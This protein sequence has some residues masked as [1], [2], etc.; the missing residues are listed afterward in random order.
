MVAGVRRELPAMVKLALPVVAAELGWVAMSLVDTIMVG[1]VSSV[2]L[3]A[4]SIGGTL[5][6]TLATFAAGLM[7]GLDTL[8]AQAYGA[9]DVRDCHR[10]LMNAVYLYLPLAPVIMFAVWWVGPGLAAF[11]VNR[12][13][14]RQA[15]EYLR[16]VAWGSLPLL[17]Y[18]AFRRYLQA[19][20]LVK[21]VMFAL[22]SA[23]LV[24]LLANW[25]FIYGNWGAPALGAMG[26]GWAT[27]YSRVYMAGC[28]IA[29]TAWH[30]RKYRTGWM[31]VS[32]RPDWGRMRSLLRLGLPAGFQ[33]SL[34]VG[35]F[36]AATALVGRLAPVTLAAH[37][38]VL[39][40][41]TITYMV[42]LAIGS[43]AAV[44]V[45]QAVGRG[46]KE[47]ARFAGWTAILLG[48]A[49][50]SLMGL[51]F[52]VVPRGILRVFT[53][54][55][56]V[57]E[58]GVALLFVAAVFQLFDGVQ[59]VS[60]GALRGLGDTDTPMICNLVGYWLV[61]LPVGYWLCF[62]RGVGAVGLWVGLCFA[63]ILIGAA[64]LTVWTQ[65]SALRPVLASTG[66]R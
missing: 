16:A 49:F 59:T 6:Y 45:G 53:E 20:N 52:L 55:A 2:A 26:A 29:Y 28:L 36:A 62:T 8:V 11:G 38:I 42:P 56:G 19:M 50:M 27:C 10:S 18:F 32:L 63:L 9:G 1:R 13:V 14:A 12:E 34:E 51:L 7:L 17:L 23:N 47:S 43:A 30:E 57:I 4:V 3:G 35:V 60:T 5:F 40:C 66:G 44:R 46:D 22:I 39:N 21:P 64:L 24:H 33:I 25:I 61:G 65:K 31:D 48:A 58:Q 54:D 15:N 41:A 37:Q